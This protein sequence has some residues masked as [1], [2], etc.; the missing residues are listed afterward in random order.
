MVAALIIRDQKLLLVHNIKHGLR[1]EPPGGKVE[2][3]ESSEEAVIREVREE[4]GVTVRVLDELGVYRTESPEGA[5]D[6]H[7]IFCEIDPPDQVIE[8][9]E[10]EKIGAYGWFTLEELRTLRDRCRKE[11]SHLL[12]PNVQMALEDMADRLSA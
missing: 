4:L 12:V 5:F 3:R 7:M 2:E 8:L 1:M 6:V 11:A 10:P 9:R